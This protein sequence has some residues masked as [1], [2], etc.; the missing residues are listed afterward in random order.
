MK[1]WIMLILSVGIL[2]GAAPEAE[3]D[4]LAAME[5]WRHAMMKKDRAGLQK[6]LHENLTYTHS[7]GL[8]ETK[9][10][11]LQSV[12]QGPMI[13]EEI[14]LSNTTVHVFGDTALVKGIVDFRNSVAGAVS[15]AH[16]DVL[17]V[18]L[19][20]PQGWQLVA[21]QAIRLP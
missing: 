7:S 4:V 1:K 9:A 5:T 8:N 19:K 2:A 13:H 21:R 18:W 12:T 6:I 11:V 15:T 17:H 10:D 16:L 3:K 20:G 14:K